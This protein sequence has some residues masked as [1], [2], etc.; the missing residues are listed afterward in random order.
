MEII[1]DRHGKCARIVAG[2]VP[3]AARY[4]IIGDET[5]ADAI[6]DRIVSDAHQIEL[7]GESLRR[8]KTLNKPFF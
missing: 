5:I 6:L 7:N 4:D 3:V 1:E 8:K 2:Q